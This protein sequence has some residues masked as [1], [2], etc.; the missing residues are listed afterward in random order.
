MSR[1]YTANVEVQFRDLDPYNHVN[2]AVYAS[3]LEHARTQYYVDVFGKKSYDIDSVVVSIHID[4]HKPAGLEDVLSIE[5]G[6]KEVG[7]SSVTRFYEIKR[8]DEL[9]ATAE[10]TH[11]FIDKKTNKSK[12]IPEDHRNTLVEY[13]QVDA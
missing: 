7:R 3:Y 1:R 9:I 4:Y 11:V 10:S 5:I 8:D 12:L 13:H 6:L 2:H